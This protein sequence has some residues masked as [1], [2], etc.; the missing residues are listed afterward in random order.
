MPR[1]GLSMLAMFMAVL[2][3][4]WMPAAALGEDAVHQ[5]GE[6]KSAHEGETHKK[7]EE[8]PDILSPRFDLTLWTIVV[9]GLLLFVLRKW[10]WGPMLQ[11]LQSRE[12]T[13]R[14]ALDEAERARKETAQLRDRVEAEIRK[15]QEEA[16]QVVGQAAHD[17]QRTGEELISKAK[18]EIQAE[19]DRLRREMETARDQTLKD[20]M[21]YMAGFNRDI[22]QGARPSAE[23]GRSPAPCGPGTQ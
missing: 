20:L 15:A 7:E 11:G 6:A 3:C 2:L 21:D 1:F 19:R 16:A 22:L 13:I 4:V 14:Q 18:T 17:A 9:F 10:A 5:P 8:K 23:R 12:E